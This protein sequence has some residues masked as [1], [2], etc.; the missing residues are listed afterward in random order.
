MTF[1]LSEYPKGCVSLEGKQPLTCYE[2]I[3]LKVGCVT[4]GAKFPGKL[5][6]ARL[7]DLHML[8]IV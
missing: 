3:W 5:N 8:N 7:R 2:N 6:D 4:Q 1:C